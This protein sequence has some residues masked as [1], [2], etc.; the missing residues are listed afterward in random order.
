MAIKSESGKLYWYKNNLED[1]NSFNGYHSFEAY[2]YKICTPK[3]DIEWLCN[4]VTFDSDFDYKLSLEYFPKTWGYEK[5]IEFLINKINEEDYIVS[6]EKELKSDA[7]K[8]GL[9]SIDD[10]NEPY[11][12][13]D[14]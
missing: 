8:Q 12:K 7:M 13:A 5:I 14:K 3:D 11:I 6:W 1:F 4:I 9:H 10:F 2:I